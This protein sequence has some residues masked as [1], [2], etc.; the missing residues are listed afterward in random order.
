MKIFNGPIPSSCARP[1][2]PNLLATFLLPSDPFIAS[3][4][5]ASLL[6]LWQTNALAS[7]VATCFRL[8]DATVACHLQG[9]ISEAWQPS[10][11]YSAGQQVNN[12]S[13]IYSN[14][15]AGVS[16]S[17]GLGPIGISP[18]IQ[19]GSA[20]WAYLAQSPDIVLSSTI[21]QASSQITVQSFSVTAGNA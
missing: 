8:Y 1:D 15:L 13:G 21:I 16:A 2:P 9:F 10:I 20:V 19:D 12:A 3:N 6:G 7:G 5:V 18:S 4:G 14:V 17:V 11:A